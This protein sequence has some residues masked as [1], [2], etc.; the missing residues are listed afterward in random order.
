MKKI[1]Q[2]FALALLLQAN[3]YAQP[4]P[5]TNPGSEGQANG[6]ITLTNNSTVSGPIKDNMRKKGEVI[7]QAD[8]KKTRYKAGEVTSVQ[9]GNTH[10]I[11][12]NY[13]FYEVVYKGKTLELLRKASEPQGLQYNGSEAAVVSSEGDIDDLFV[14]KNGGTLTLL[15]KKNSKDVLPGCAVDI[16]KFDAESIKKAVEGCDK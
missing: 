15:T 10:Y 13:T 12:S 6:V 14:R 5:S 7:L 4:G 2:L 3:A 8:G 9:I 16:A 1:L 11:T